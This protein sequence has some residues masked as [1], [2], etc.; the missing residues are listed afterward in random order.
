MSTSVK[1]LTAAKRVQG[2][3]G[4]ARAVRRQG[5]IP[6]VIYG[7]GDAPVSIS[8]DQKIA[9]QLI[10][11]GHFLTTQFDIDVDGEKSRVLPRDYQLDPVTD[12]VMHVDFLRLRQ[13]QQ[14]RVDV[15]VHFSNSEASPGLKRGGTMNVVRHTVEL[16]VP[17]DNIPAS[18]EADLTGLEIGDSLH[19]SA[20]KL[21]DNCRPVIND[22][23][24]TVATI[25]APSGLKEADADDAA[26]AAA[27][28]AS[29]AAAGKP[30][31]KK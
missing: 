8:L 11:A 27:A 9:S 7:G 28:A 3:K 4:A 19:I 6:A 29:A 5:Q 26:A 16:F 14:I 15:P 21:P 2:G 13:G 23:D 1:Q 25:V 31:A 17:A 18:L 30:A 12:R 24:F 22:R 10:F 20:I